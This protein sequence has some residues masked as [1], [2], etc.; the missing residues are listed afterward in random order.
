MTLE[1]NKIGRKI[2][3]KYFKQNIEVV[4][5]IDDNNWSFKLEDGTILKAQTP[6][7]YFDEEI[8]R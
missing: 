3:S 4:E 8:K 7:S 5:F 6:L 2:Y 1:E